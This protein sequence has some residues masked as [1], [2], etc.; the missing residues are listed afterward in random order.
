MH[1]LPGGV[2]VLIAIR[3]LM[4]VFQGPMLPSFAQL[5]SAWVPTVERA[6]LGTFAYS[7]MVVSVGVGSF[8]SS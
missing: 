6:F 2:N 8:H 1:C 7:G 4:G 3:I 5:L